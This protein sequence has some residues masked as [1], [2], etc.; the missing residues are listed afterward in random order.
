MIDVNGL[1]ASTLDLSDSAFLQGDELLFQGHSQEAIENLGCIQGKK[2][3]VFLIGQ[4]IINKGDILTLSSS[5][6]C[7]AGNRILLKTK[8][9]KIYIHPNLE[10]LPAET[11]QN[12]PYS[13][14]IRNRGNIQALST[15]TR[16]GEIYLVA[17]QGTVQAEGNSLLAADHEI[18]LLGSVVEV[19]DQSELSTQASGTIQIGGS[20]GGRNPLVQSAKETF[21][22]EEVKIT[23]NSAP[24]GDGGSVSVFATDY[25]TFHGSIEA[26]G[27]ELGGDG[28]IVEVSG[29]QG[30]SFKGQVDTRAPF[31]DDGLLII[32]P[33]TVTISAGGTSGGMF[34]LGN[35]RVFSLPGDFSAPNAVLNITN[36]NNV[37]QT[38]NVS[39]ETT[40]GEAGNGDIIIGSAT[41]LNL[42]NSHSLTLNAERD[43]NV[44]SSFSMIDLD[45]GTSTLTMNALGDIDLTNIVTGVNL[46]S[47]NMNAGGDILIDNLLIGDTL[48]LIA[49]NDII[50]QGGGTNVITANQC[51]LNATND[52]TIIND[53]TFQGVGTN[54]TLTMTAGVDFNH[55][56]VMRFNNWENVNA[57]TTTGDF[58]VDNAV[59]TTNTSSITFSS[60][61][62]LIN[63]G[64]TN[65]FNDLTGNF[66]DLFL[67]A[68]QDV[69]ID[70][71]ID[72]NNF[73]SCTIQP[74]RD[75]LIENDFEPDNTTTVSVIAGRDIINTDS[76]ADIIANNGTTLS[77]TAGRNYTSSQELT[78]NNF[79]NVNITAI[80]GD[81]SISG[82]TN[83]VPGANTTVTAGNDINLTTVFRSLT[84]G[85]ITFT[86]TNDINIGPSTGLSQLGVLSGTI[87][88]NAGNDLNV[89]GGSTTNDRS[90]IGFTGAFVNTNIE[91][92]VGRDINVTA[93]SNSNSI[94]HIGHGFSVA[95]TL[96]GDI[97]IHSVGRD[98]TI[99]G[100]TGPTGSTKFAQI[101]HTRFSGASTSNISGNIRGTAAGSPAQ[102]NGNLNLIGG[103]DTTSFAL[104]GHGGRDSNANETYSGD[105]RVQANAINL[106]GGASADCFAGI[107][108]FATSQVGG[109]NPIIVTS[110][111]SVEA[112]SDTTLTMTANSNG[113]VSIGGRV[114]NSAAH[115]CTMNL[116]SVRIQTGGDLTMTSGTG[117]ETDA[118][119]G[120]FCNPSAGITDTNLILSI[121]GDL[122]M[123]AGTN[124]PCQIINGT[125]TA[126]AKNTSIQ[127]AGNITPTVL[128]PTFEAYIEN[129]T[130]NLDVVAQGVIT[131]PDLTRIT[132]QGAN[133]GTLNVTGGNIF[134]V[135]GGLITNTGSGTSSVTTTSDGLF[136]SNGSSVTSAGNLTA[137]IARDLSVF[138]NALM[139]SS[140][141]TINVTAG[142]DISVTGTGGGSG[143]LSSSGN[144]QYLAGRD[145]ILRGASAAIEGVITNT[146]GFLEVIAGENIEVNPFG[147]IENQGPGSLTLVVD[148]QA[149]IAP[150]IGNGEFNLS[151][152]GSVGRIG[153]GPLRIFTAR[154]GQNSILGAGNLNGST[155]T[156]GTLFVDT[157]TEQWETYFPSSF[158]G[159]PF[160][161]FY[162]DGAIIPPSSVTP[163][164]PNIFDILALNPN[165][166]VPFFEL[167]FLLEGPRQ[168][169][170]IAWLYRFKVE[171]N[172]CKEGEKGGSMCIPDF[173]KVQRLPPCIKRTAPIRF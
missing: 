105:I 82:T 94:A 18:S 155:F 140:S 29:L 85:D 113:I 115:F 66:T 35:P 44:L 11:G 1:V 169:L 99:Q 20:F 172:W 39:I 144:G 38:S 73:K 101:G 87:Q 56:N 59:N 112:I 122:L 158:G 130:G 52:I 30:L 53:I 171:N 62:N 25:T 92:T 163:F 81:V 4:H 37:L 133:N 72:I 124:A 69:L 100:D 78:A 79:T 104:L 168:D 49:T 146:T 135:D 86:A 125:G 151:S 138:D 161:V 84:A 16:G 42:S 167:S 114:L 126:A 160:T 118:T 110:P 48:N 111:A 41:S 150:A 32:D 131:L 95:G 119:I 13:L 47:I 117:A 43:I 40:S 17:D 7:G 88:I 90:Q 14:A 36:L 109:N 134:V 67:N 9:K 164:I 83:N 27:G 128:G 129:A 8:E 121:G 10:E 60:G 5:V 173:L 26:K 147:K 156:P 166:L 58:L 55:N 12:S 148:N 142:R 19:K 136:I 70:T 71:Q 153:G 96:S 63:Q 149:P 145:I 137:S 65:L 93:G 24:F 154:Q 3:G 75:F 68:N 127:V 57:S 61:N 120:A 107:G 116:D 98:V 54:P 74:T 34:S 108:F 157:A 102:I 23:A 139:T 89:I 51:T 46:T 33:T 22:G 159:A 80:A 162:K 21:I 31:G 106:S 143:T 170:V 76:A 152:M 15:E 132:N 45:A 50:S 165:A 28:G 64:G 91:L 103:S 77:F 6:K 141:G 97:I 123:T 2:E